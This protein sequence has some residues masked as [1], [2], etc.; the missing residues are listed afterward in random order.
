MQVPN[1]SAHLSGVFMIHRK[2]SMDEELIS[3]IGVVMCIWS[4]LKEFWLI[5]AFKEHMTR[6]Q[7]FVSKEIITQKL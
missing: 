2:T 7:F 6:T 4:L 5:T 1:V 3:G